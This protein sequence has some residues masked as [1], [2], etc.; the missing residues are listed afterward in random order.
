M[1]LLTITTQIALLI[2][3][4][5][6]IGDIAATELSGHGIVAMLSPVKEVAAITAAHP[7]SSENKKLETKQIIIAQ[8]NPDKQRRFK[9]FTYQKDG[10]CI[11]NIL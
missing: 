7:I 8:A 6:A 2:T 10:S 11:E 4:C 3:L 1:E 5:I 9:Y